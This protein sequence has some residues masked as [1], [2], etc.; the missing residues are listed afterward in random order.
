MF[1]R[2]A[3]PGIRRRSLPD[4]RD[5]HSFR[6]FPVECASRTKQ[7]KLRSMPREGL[8][9][10]R[11]DPIRSPE[12]AVAPARSPGLMSEAWRPDSRPRSP[13]RT[14]PSCPTLTSSFDSDGNS[15]FSPLQEPDRGHQLTKKKTAHS[16]LVKRVCEAS[17]K[18]TRL[19]PHALSRISED[20]FEEDY[21]Q[22][23]FDV[24][25]SDLERRGLIPVLAS[26]I[27]VE[28]WRATITRRA[29]R[30]FRQVA[31]IRPDRRQPWCLMSPPE[32]EDFG[33]NCASHHQAGAWP[34]NCADS[35]SAGMIQEEIRRP[36]GSGAQR[37]G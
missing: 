30:G 24:R 35:Q 13:K 20:P 26:K 22:Q 7:G 21:L 5:F 29:R 28:E 1:W 12:S 34:R 27:I 3:P 36:G 32:K 6:G 37:P 14:D 19:S 9:L 10:G 4:D 33:R 15:F 8:L 17:P 25:S 18:A 11:D 2:S 16:R 31:R 23:I